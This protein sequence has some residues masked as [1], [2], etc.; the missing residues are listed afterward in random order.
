L[1]SKLCDRAKFSGASKTLLPSLDGA[2]PKSMPTEQYCALFAR[3]AAGYYRRCLKVD[4]RQ[5][6]AYINLIGSLERNEPKG[7]YDEIQNTAVVA[8]KQGIWYNR[9][10]R[11]P[12]FVPSLPAKPWH[13][14]SQFELCRRLEKHGDAIRAEYSAYI[15]R[16]AS[17]KAWD[18]LDTTPG[19]GDV[20]GR[21]G[22]LHDSGLTK[23]GR[24]QEVPL[25]TNCAVNHEYAELF[26]QTMKLLRQHGHDATGLALCGGG[27][28]IF[29]VLAPGTRLR[30]HCGPSNARLTCHLGI[31]VPWSASQG[32]HIRVAAE[33]PRGWEEGRCLV[34][35]DSFEH[36]VIFKEAGPSEPYPGERVVLLLNFW[37]PDFEF[38]NDPDWRSKSDTATGSVEVESLPKTDIVTFGG[39]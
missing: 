21:P 31:R 7:W 16:L 17:R 37:H 10:Q 4:P 11:P 27:D 32:L 20:G 3:A 14:A 23:S 26:P 22:A 8:V 25:V 28:V 13:D 2:D 39:S 19:L 30:P 36:E 15:E 1:L 38:K 6:P 34:F 18:D 24:W 5:R 9:W 35:D 33:T 29:S 12:H